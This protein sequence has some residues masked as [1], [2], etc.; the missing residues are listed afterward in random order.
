MKAIKNLLKQNRHQIN[1][2]SIAELIM[3]HNLEAVQPLYT[4]EEAQ[5]AQGYCDGYPYRHPVTIG[6]QTQCT[7]YDAGHILGSA[8]CIIRANVNGR[9]FTVGF[10]GDLGRFGKPILKNP[11]LQFESED[12]LLDLLIM[13]STY[14]DRQHP[15]VVDMKPHLKQVIEETAARGGSVLI[16]SFA[17]GRTQELL[18]TLH[19]LYNEGALKPL[20]VYVDSPLATRLTRV[21]GE[22][23]EVY[24][25]DTHRTF[26][27][28]GAN[29]FAF[30]QI[31][32]VTSVE[33]SM[34]LNRE[35]KPHVVIAASGMCEAGRILHHLRFK[36]HNPQHT[37]LIVGYMARHTLGRR[38]QEMGEAYAAQDRKGP[39]PVVR[40]LNKE[41]PLQAR[42]VKLGGFSAHGDRA[43]MTHFLE[44]SNLQ[45]KK[46]A[47]VHG[48]EDQ[49]LSFAEYLRGRGFDAIV[50]AN[51]ETLR[52]G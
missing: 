7:L 35:E 20:P 32:F 24:D 19:A 22:H 21:F 51:G 43:E 47:L 37:V 12:R 44:A 17:F 23:P 34:A 42:V 36:I 29:P 30:K 39:A 45:I 11:T 33:E 48:E 26:L 5:N 31:R 1:R 6:R 46:I 16:P 9:V 25:R 3:R 50:P 52:I 10:T 8:I 49:S 4:I 41:Y 13:E 40:I 38:I 28:N 2:E 18:Y 14:G 27:E 15:P